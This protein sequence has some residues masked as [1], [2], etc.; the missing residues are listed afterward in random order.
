MSK[1]IKVIKKKDLA[2]RT[3]NAIREKSPT[4]RSARKVV[5]NVSGWVSEF[6]MRKREETKKAIESIFKNQPQNAE[7]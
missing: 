5:T 1:K 2:S 3:G 7:S 4:K 6:Q